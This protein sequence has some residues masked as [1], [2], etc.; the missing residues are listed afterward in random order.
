MLFSIVGSDVFMINNSKYSWKKAVLSAA[1]GIQ[2]GVPQA[3]AID[4]AG[5]GKPRRLQIRQRAFE[6]LQL[7]GRTHG[8]PAAVDP[9]VSASLLSSNTP[10]HFPNAP[11]RA[12]GIGV[13]LTAKDYL[14]GAIDRELIVAALRALRRRP[15]HKL[16]Q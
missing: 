3:S 9:T 10:P 7:G 4:S 6:L 8:F 16:R 14:V 12:L 5:I 1:A 15:R 2:P 11:V 13:R